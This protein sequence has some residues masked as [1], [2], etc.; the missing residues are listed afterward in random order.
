MNLKD[1]Q[2]TTGSKYHANAT[3]T[4]KIR[5]DSAKE[6]KRYIYLMQLQKAGK[7]KN[8]KLQHQFTL[9]EGFKTT[10]GESVRPIKYVA[11][12]TYE[13]EEGNFII[14]DVKSEYTRGLKEYR[15]KN[16]LMASRGYK[17]TEVIE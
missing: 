5:F 13:D 12:F 1:S 3:E 10:D 15:L 7:I 9:Q 6:A 17:I 2:E 11:D 16:R 8:L 14:E 4:N